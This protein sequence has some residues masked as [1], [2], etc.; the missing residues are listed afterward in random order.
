MG[1]VGQPTVLNWTVLRGHRRRLVAVTVQVGRT[2]AWAVIDSGM[3]R[4]MVA[5]RTMTS[6]RMTPT[7]SRMR[8]GGEATMPGRGRLGRVG[9]RVAVK[10]GST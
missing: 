10:I 1:V 7:T 8:R 3:A 5:W 6:R 2:G 9:H 4:Q